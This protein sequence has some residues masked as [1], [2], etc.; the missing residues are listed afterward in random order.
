MTTSHGALL[1]IGV[2][3][4]PKLRSLPGRKPPPEGVLPCWPLGLAQ[5]RGRSLLEAEGQAG[6]HGALSSL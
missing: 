2:W 5:S 4:P 6:G 3:V 1:P